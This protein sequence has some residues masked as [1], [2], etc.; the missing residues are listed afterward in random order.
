[1]LMARVVTYELSLLRNIQPK[2]GNKFN[3]WKMTIFDLKIVLIENQFQAWWC[4]EFQDKAPTNFA[5]K[6]KSHF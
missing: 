1:M 5:D 4:S 2:C 6:A 3:C